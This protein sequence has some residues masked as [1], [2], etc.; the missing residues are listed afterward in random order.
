MDEDTSTVEKVT[1]MEDILSDSPI[2]ANKDSSNTGKVKVKKGKALGI[3]VPKGKPKSGRVWKEQKERYVECYL[4][5]LY[6]VKH[7]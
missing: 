7:A 6:S 3:Q 4:S 1:R 5:N 2:V